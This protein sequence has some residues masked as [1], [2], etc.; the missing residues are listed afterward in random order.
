MARGWE[1]K[2][3]EAQQEER[4]AARVKAAPVTPEEAARRA[5]VQRLEASRAR[6][7]ADLATATAAAH[8]RMLKAALADLDLQI[9]RA[10]PPK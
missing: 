6:V 9:Q 10:Q 4:A 2:S 1:S 8:K 3:V 7:A 5:L